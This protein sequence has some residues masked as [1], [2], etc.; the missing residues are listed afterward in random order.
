VAAVRLRPQPLVVEFV[1]HRIGPHSKG[2]DTRDQHIIDDARGNDWLRH[3]SDAHA[4]QLRRVDAE[5]GRR[6]DAVVAEVLRRSP[7]AWERS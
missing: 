1:T 5:Q 6:V 4:D 3:Y 2:D 7:S